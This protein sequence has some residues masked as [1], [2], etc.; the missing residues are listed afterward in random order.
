MAHSSRRPLTTYSRRRGHRR[1]ASDHNA[2]QSSPIRSLSPDADDVSFAVMANR[3]NKRARLVSRS[4]DSQAGFSESSVPK[5]AEDRPSKRQ[6]AQPILSDDDS[7]MGDYMRDR[8]APTPSQFCTPQVSMPSDQSMAHSSGTR[9][10][11]APDQL[12]PLPVARRILSRTSSRN[13]KEN[14]G[15]RRLASPF[16]SRPGSRASSPDKASRGSRKRTAKHVKSRTL[17]QS[18]PL[19]EKV[20]D[21]NLVQPLQQTS[22]QLSLLAPAAAPNE[23]HAKPNISIHNR[24]SSTPS[25]Q[26]VLDQMC[27]EAWL[28][29]PKALSRSLVTAQTA[30]GTDPQDAVTAHASFFEDE[31]MHISTPRRKR[32]ATVGVWK[33]G[34]MPQ[35]DAD[36][37]PPVR[38]LR[39]DSDVDMSDSS[40][41]TSP[42]D[43]RSTR[44]GV[45]RRRRR[46]IVHLPSDS[47]F[48]SS[49]DFSALMSETERFPRAPA[50]EGSRSPEQ[51]PPIEDL[52]LGP[53][54]SL[55]NSPSAC[56]KSTHSAARTFQASGFSVSVP[57]ALPGTPPSS[58]SHGRPPVPA[59]PDSD[60]DELLDL[61]SVLGLDEDEKWDAAPGAD[62]SGVAFTLSRT[63]SHDS[64]LSS[65]SAKI[66]RRKRGDTIRASDYT[67]LPLS[68]SSASFDSASAAGGSGAHRVVPKR[69][70]SGTV[71]QANLSGGPKRKHEGWPTIKMRTS[72]E[73]LRADED[74]DDELLLKDGD[75]IE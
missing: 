72:A 32:S 12:S 23:L 75:V 22:P 44:P 35:L 49:L 65:S 9:P 40:R 71:T 63:Q 3:M 39:Y 21:R 7:P 59:N 41:P 11:P 74:E 43:S 34:L 69:T 29:P 17:S 20:V 73:P 38:S 16:S 54:F 15:Q 57:P 4:T 6:K 36:P 52:D 25:L 67:K 28:V 33:H 27:S 19:R 2:T 5:A 30:T 50:S 10:T 53:A 1:K 18:G 26:P 31:P 46:T 64:K 45:P 48:S 62:D 61:F 14:A 24:S 55:N 37:P 58:P 68:G 13:F 51:H 8:R 47:L 42:S 70:R 60:N 66:A 56:R